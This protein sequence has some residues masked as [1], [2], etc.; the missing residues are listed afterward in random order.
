MRFFLARVMKKKD[1]S[2]WR[3]EELALPKNLWYGEE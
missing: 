3:E 2:R 1:G